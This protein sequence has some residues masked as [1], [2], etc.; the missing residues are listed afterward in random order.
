MTLR[1]SFSTIFLMKRA[2]KIVALI[3]CLWGTARFC[4]KQTA[5]FTVTR[6]SSDLPFHPEWEVEEQL[7][8][9]ELTN[10]L[11]QPYHFLGKGAQAFAFASEDGKAVIKFFKHHRLSPAPWLKAV[12]FATRS[13]DK[14]N[15]KL[16]K[17]FT[18]Y[19]LAYEKL[20]EETGLLYLHLNTAS[21]LGI[22]L[23]LVD[24]LG[25]HH[26]VPLDRYTF[27]VQRRAEDSYETVRAWV[28]KGQMDAAKRGITSLV[29][30]LKTRNARGIY[31]KDPDINTN[32]GFVGEAAIQIDVG[33]FRMRNG[34]ADPGEYAR[35]TDNLHQH[36]MA[37]SPELDKHLQEELQK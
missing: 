37:L 29:Q 31:D 21:K 15:S 11:S 3:L 1:A 20:R 19:R 13:S 7:S 14:K 25:I 4:K 30:L 8:Q 27:L 18:S 23:D 16:I 26:P 33:R 5:G 22:V 28:E 17:D 34:P 35:I 10:L 6:I 9:E 24:R 2:L 36:L 32:F 12:P